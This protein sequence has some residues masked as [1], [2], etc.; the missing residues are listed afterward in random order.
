MATAGLQSLRTLGNSDLHLSPIGFGAWALGGGDWQFG[1][2]NQDDNESIAAIHRALELG[3]NWIDTAAVYGLG[4]SEEVVARAVKSS[5]RKP[6]VFTKC[7]RRWNAERQIYGAL[8]PESVLEEL[9][10]SL[11]RLGVDTIDLYQIHWPNPEEDIEAAWE[12]LVRAREQGKI[13]WAGVSNFSAAQMERIQRI[14]PITSLQPPYS[15]LRRAV[16]ETILPFAQAHDIGVINYSPMV[17]GL[18]TGKMTAER[19][20]A[21]PENDWRRNNVEFKEPRLS[22]NL[23]LV[24]LLREIGSS[25]GVTPGVVAVAW[26][27]HNPAIT[28]AIVGG[29]SPRQV[30]ELAPAL[31]FRLTED[32]FARINKFLADNPV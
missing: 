18:L 4:H 30:E 23:R 5:G 10:G 7:A 19:A 25:R 21:M 24:D 8:K 12:T 13:R 2:G 3:V 29:R 26:T 11:R 17:S 32:E 1:W 22:R 31:E 9:E 15:M 6:Y 28:A 16:E 27:L 14:A 20:A